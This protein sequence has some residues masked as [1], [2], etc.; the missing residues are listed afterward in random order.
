MTTQSEI[1][2][3]NANFETFKAHYDFLAA[4]SKAENRRV[5]NHLCIRVDDIDAAEQL[6]SPI[7]WHRKLYPP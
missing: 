4:K 7:L 3:R 5:L 2:S 1:D 6:L